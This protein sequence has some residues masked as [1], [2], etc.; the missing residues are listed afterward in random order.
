MTQIEW[1][2][3]ANEQ[4][5]TSCSVLFV[6]SVVGIAGMFNRW[7][8]GIYGLIASLL[9]VVLEWPRGRRRK[10]N[11]ILRRFQRPF[12]LLVDKLGI[13]GRNYFIRFIAYLLMCIPCCFTLATLLGGICLLCTGA[14]YFL[15]A[16]K[17]EEWAPAGLEKKSDIKQVNSLHPPKKAP[18][19][20]NTRDTGSV[21]TENIDMEIVENSR[22][23]ASEPSRPRRPP[24]R[25]TVVS[26]EGVQDPRG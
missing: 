23:G 14:I 11:T 24:P 17:G 26:M 21:D 7:Q 6:G 10:G 3:W 9:I 19:R 18:P 13:A 2:M 22:G 1:A 8:F 12:T 4:A 5:L 16:I 25:P 20:L 15:A